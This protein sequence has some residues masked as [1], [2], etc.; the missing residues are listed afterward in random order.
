VHAIRRAAVFAEW[1]LIVLFA[2]ILLAI[3]VDLPMAWN[4]QPCSVP[5]V[6][7][8]CYPWGT[9]GPAGEHWNYGSKQTYLASSI[10][11]AV[12]I[13]A[14]FSGAFFVSAGRRILVLLPLGILWGLAIFVF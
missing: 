1:L 7:H 10:V 6:S 9:E 8:D 3:L 12:L 14:A 2:F 4:A 13:C 5:P 11:S